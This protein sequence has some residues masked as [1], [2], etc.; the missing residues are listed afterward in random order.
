MCYLETVFSFL[1]NA[2]RVRAKA[3]HTQRE[4]SSAEEDL[5][6]AWQTNV[7]HSATRDKPIASSYDDGQPSQ[8][9]GHTV[10]FLSLV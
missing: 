7:V 3:K 5:H 1:Q 4:T 2:R 10:M 6:T 8:R 9:A